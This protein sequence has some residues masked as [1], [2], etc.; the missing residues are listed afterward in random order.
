MNTRLPLLG[1]VSL[2]LAG[3]HPAEIA[4]EESPSPQVRGDH[5]QLPPDSPQMASLSVETAKECDPVSMSLNGRLTWD[6]KVTV[7]VF[8]PFAGR[9]METFGEVGQT[10]ERGAVLAKLASPDFSQAQAEA[11]RSRADEV[12]AHRTLDRVRDLHLHGAAPQKDVDAAEADLER[13]TT[14]RRRAE[15]RL[16]FYG[17]S[18]DATDAAFDLKAPI[19]GVIVEKNLSPGQEVRPDQMLA[20]APQFFAPMFVVTDPTKLWVWIDVDESRVSALKVGQKLVLRAH[21]MPTETFDAIIDAASEML[22]PVSHTFKVRASVDNSRR[23]LK[24]EMWV[25]IDFPTSTHGV[26]EVLER[27]VFL[28]GEKHYVFLQIEKGK[29]ARRE[30]V[31]GAQTHGRVTILKGIEPGQQIVVEGSLLLEQVYQTSQGS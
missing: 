13:T 5:V 15:S 28:K 26:A 2:L 9:V 27:A 16:A 17:A 6:D 8:T 18:P 31:P 3:C 12:L 4:R 22:D 23:L 29:F 30:V 21:S 1:L 10:V 7:R 19:G 11:R 24:A 25:T 20:N 14:E